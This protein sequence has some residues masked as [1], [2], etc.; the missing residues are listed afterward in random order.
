MSHCE[1]LKGYLAGFMEDEPARF[2]ESHLE[3]CADCRHEVE[4][5]QVVDD[6]F[7]RWMVE[8]DL[9]RA[10]TLRAEALIRDAEA[11][12]VPVAW[13][14]RV[15]PSVV[16][17][18]IA[19]V[20][21]AWFLWPS[22]TGLQDASRP[23]EVAPL[24]NVEILLS[25][26]GELEPSKTEKQY[27]IS[28]PA[29]GRMVVNASGDRIALGDRSRATLGASLRQATTIR[30]LEGSVVVRAKQREQSERL[31]L[32]A[33]VYRVEVLGTCFGVTLRGSEQIEIAVSEGRV[34]VSRPRG[35]MRIVEAGQVLRATQD[36]VGTPT[37]LD[38]ARRQNIERLLSPR[39]MKKESVLLRGEKTDAG[40][41]EGEI[42]I[43]LDASAQ[44]ARAVPKRQP[45]RHETQNKFNP[46]HVRQL[47]IRGDYGRALS[48]LEG[49][50]NRTP[51]DAIAWTLLANCRRKTGDWEQAVY[52]YRKV[53]EVAGPMDGNR[54]RFKSAAIY[55]DKLGRHGDAIGLLR[56]YLK[57][58]ARL[59]PH[60]AEAKYRLAR[61]LRAIGRTE[62]ANEIL[63]EIIAAHAGSS[64]AEQARQLLSR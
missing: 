6:E 35:P 47:I 18:T 10:T 23:G 12:P 20:A 49:H 33:G 48:V 40:L 5:Q 54:A 27:A 41:A 24:L 11:A 32:L 60:Q 64:A 29:A 7:R 57:R 13:K 25:E 37:A 46:D 39:P 1:D 2:F 38:S 4:K 3:H 17:A 9:P 31:A 14:R 36:G 61:S 19:I 59:K 8:R 34:R 56:S 30:L 43:P 22:S 26:G 62:K 55:Q 53:V 44:T 15:V 52:A 16:A 45:H 50:L 28:V 42:D 21:A 51:Q 63:E 58:D